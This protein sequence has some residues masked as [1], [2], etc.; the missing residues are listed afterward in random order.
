MN[1]CRLGSV[2]ADVEVE[3]SR[4][5]IFPD[6]NIC[7][8]EGQEAKLSRDLEEWWCRSTEP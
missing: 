8:R 5:G 6:I 7:K 1:C 2:D 3:F 4:Q